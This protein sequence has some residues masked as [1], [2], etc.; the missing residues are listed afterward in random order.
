MSEMTSWY[1]RHEDPIFKYF[2]VLFPLAPI[3][4]LFVSVSH[5][6]QELL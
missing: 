5:R 2:F 6:I 1:Q 4:N 3:S